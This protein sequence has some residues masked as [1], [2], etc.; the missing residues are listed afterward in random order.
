MCDILTGSME[1]KIQ[2]IFQE[3]FFRLQCGEIQYK[4]TLKITHN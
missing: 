1:K 3:S 4:A 2:D